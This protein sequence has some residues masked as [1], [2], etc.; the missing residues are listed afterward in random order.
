MEPILNKIVEY[1]PY[2]N[3]EEG[4]L[5]FQPALLDYND[6]VGRSGIGRIKR[7]TIKVNETVS[8]VRLDGSIKQFRIQK[9]FGFMD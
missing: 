5:Q 3:V 1:I 9:L 8:C 6:Y 7:G 4:T 2:P